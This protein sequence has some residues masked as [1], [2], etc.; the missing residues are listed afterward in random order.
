LAG[1][2]GDL[3][4]NNR[5]R[6]LLVYGPGVEYNFGKNEDYKKIRKTPYTVITV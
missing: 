2:T 4:L 1:V 3:S 5:R 6:A